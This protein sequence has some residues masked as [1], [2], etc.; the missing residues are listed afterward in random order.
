[1]PKPPYMYGAFPE[2]RKR[3]MMNGMSEFEDAWST[4]TVIVHAQREIPVY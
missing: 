4:E 2:A 1:M 3:K